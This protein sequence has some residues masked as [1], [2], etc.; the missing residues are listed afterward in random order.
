MALVKF[1]SALPT[2]VDNFFNR[3][4]DNFLAPATPAQFFGNLPAVNVIESQEGYKLE[5]AAPG[6]KKEDFK[7]S[8]HTNKLTISAS[9]ENKTEESNEKY[10]RREFSFGAFQRTFTL[11]Q[12]VNSEQI[13]ANYVDGILTVTLPKKEEAKPKEPRLIDIA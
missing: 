1:N 5:V 7:L 4:F 10:T 3:E 9:Q 13:A 11:P 2:L 12:T 6:L 8:L